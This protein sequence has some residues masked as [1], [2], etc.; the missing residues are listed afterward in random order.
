MCGAPTP[1]A[2]SEGRPGRFELAHG[3]TLC[4]DEVG[5]LPLDVQPLLL[6]AL[7]EGVIYR[8]GSPQPRRVDVRLL[9]LTNR[10]LAEDVEAGRFR[11]DLF[12]RVAVTRV[13]IPPLREREGDVDRLAEHFNRQLAARHGVAP[14]RFGA[15]VRAYLR[16]YE[17]PGNVRE[18][19]NLIEGLLLTATRPEVGLDEIRAALPPLGPRPG[20][21][22]VG[23]VP[24]SP[25]TSLDA[26]ERAAIVNVVLETSGNLALAARL[27]GISR[28]TLYR[29]AARYGISLP[30]LSRGERAEGDGTERP[31]G[32]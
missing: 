2:T 28:S 26:T 21:G 22:L 24:A 15:E 3:G 16:R 19:R 7:E 30:S 10:T 9:A 17:W 18:L 25:T 27:L 6:R 11:R 4:L 14:R 12:Y 5:E 1:G 20:V 31:V 29:K 23:A 8:L 13:R 32:H